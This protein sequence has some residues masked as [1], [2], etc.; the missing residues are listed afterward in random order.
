[1]WTTNERLLLVKTLLIVVLLFLNACSAQ[2]PVDDDFLVDGKDPFDDEFFADSPKWDSSVLQQ[3]EVLSSTEPM[4]ESDEP[5][6]FME[7]S[8]EALFGTVLVGG[9]VAKLLFLP[10]LGL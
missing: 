2:K 3:S 8:E 1:M 10:F 7:K 9:M 6:S 5:K 4:K